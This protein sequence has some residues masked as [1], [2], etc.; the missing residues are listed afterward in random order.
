MA[1]KSKEENDIFDTSKVSQEILK[2]NP[3]FA[4]D[5]V[6]V[7]SD[8]NASKSIKTLPP[9]MQD[10]DVPT[11]TKMP[12]G[13]G[14]PPVLKERWLLV[15]QN[16]MLR[17]VTSQRK[18]QELTD[19]SLSTVNNLCN[20]VRDRLSVDI[21]IKR[22]NFE[23]E[24][25]YAE[26]EKIANFCWGMIENDPL[27][28]QV[29][30]YLKIVGD[31]TSRRAKLMGLENAQITTAK[32]ETTNNNLNIFSNFGINEDSIKNIA[33]SLANEFNKIENV[34]KDN[35]IL[36]VEIIEIEKDTQ[37]KGNKNG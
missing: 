6:E 14:M 26:N 3:E 10:L 23:R 31:T 13:L 37:E 30:T 35:N 7:H 8:I 16:L 29:P 5:L 27:S 19:L 18:I 12:I 4:N 11:V 1:R 33:D 36:D 34:K 17:G 24:K 28:N 20:E 21:D 9:I 22:V 32:N 25:L 15:V 2:T